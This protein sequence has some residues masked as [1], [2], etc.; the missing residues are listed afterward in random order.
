MR[1]EKQKWDT[2]QFVPPPK[3]SRKKIRRRHYANW[4]SS[5]FLAQYDHR[6]VSFSINSTHS[7]FKFGGNDWWKA[8]WKALDLKHILTFKSKAFHQSFSPIVYLLSVLW[9]A[10]LYSSWPGSRFSWSHLIV[11]STVVTHY[12]RV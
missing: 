6:L 5:S 7:N 12:A 11:I 1:G 3:T 8:W 9:M 4:F 2:I 10:M